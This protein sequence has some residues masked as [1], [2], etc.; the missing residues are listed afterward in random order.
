[1]R[2]GS[3]PR[4]DPELLALSILGSINSFVTHWVTERKGKI[5][6]YRDGVHALID[7]WHSGGGGRAI[8]R[9]RS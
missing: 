1:V 8:R 4:L 9:V 7:A 2:E 5:S 3:L 6:L